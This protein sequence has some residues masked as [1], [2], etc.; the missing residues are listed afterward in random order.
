MR[1]ITSHQQTACIKKPND[2]C[3]MENLLKLSRKFHEA[4]NLDARSTPVVVS[5]PRMPSSAM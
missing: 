3:W 2:R 1:L 4:M 5:Q